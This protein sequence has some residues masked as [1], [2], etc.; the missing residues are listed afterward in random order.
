MLSPIIN[1]MLMYLFIER[2]DD[3]IQNQWIFSNY[4]IQ[5][6]QKEKKSFFIFI[7]LNKTT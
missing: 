7:I 2:K 5:F 4:M 6:N 3:N 1:E